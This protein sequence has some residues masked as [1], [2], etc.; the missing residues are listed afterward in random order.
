MTLACEKCLSLRRRDGSGTSP[1]YKSNS[2]AT[3]AL[4]GSMQHA[5]MRRINEKPTQLF[6]QADL[7]RRIPSDRPPCAIRALVDKVLAGLSRMCTKLYVRESS[8]G[9]RFSIVERGGGT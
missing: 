6:N 3:H 9:V 1:P 2:L 5:A 7:G 4:S 8:Y